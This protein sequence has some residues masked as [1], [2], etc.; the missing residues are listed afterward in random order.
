MQQ[1][2]T[3]CPAVVVLAKG[4]AQGPSQLQLRTQLIAHLLGGSLRLH[5]DLTIL[6]RVRLARR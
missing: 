3:R 5:V 2:F 4:K 6:G 1:G